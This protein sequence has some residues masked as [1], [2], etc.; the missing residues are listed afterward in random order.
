MCRTA[1]PDAPIR[2]LAVEHTVALLPAT[3]RHC[4][5]T[6][7]R[8]ALAS[9]EAKCPSAPDVKCAAH[10]DGCE[11]MGRESDRAAHQAECVIVRLCARFDVER[12]ETSQA[13]ASVVD[14][15][16][17]PTTS[18]QAGKNNA[19]RLAAA[20]DSLAPLAVRLIAGGGEID[21]CD[22]YTPLCIACEHGNV[23]MVERLI[24]AGSLVNNA[25]FDGATPLYL[26]GQNNRLDVVKLLIAAG[27]DVNTADVDEG[28]TPLHVAAEHGHAG[29]VSVLVETAGVDLN[30]AVL[31][32]GE[33]AGC[34]P[35]L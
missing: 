30:A 18:A 2:C 27:A 3:C 25:S 31:T 11:W 19:L 34:T 23:A 32:D 15:L 24:A 22:G 10:A 20:H 17:D 16:L 29:V 28:C 35:L 9:H 33:L 7:T 1:L 6:T 21:P 5:E 13:T 8:G 26:A 12:M 4:T 14:A